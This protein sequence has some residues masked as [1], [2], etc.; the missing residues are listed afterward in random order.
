VL[1]IAEHW[2]GSDLG[3]QRQGN[4]DNYFVRAP[5]FVVAD[6]MGGA[7]AGEVAS[8]IAASSF[9]NGLPSGGTVAEGL[10][11]IIEDANR[12]IHDRSRS[13]AD[14]A[15]MGTTVTAA[16]VG[17]REVTVA[18]V[19]DSRAY[20]VRDGEVVRLTRDHSLVNELIERGKL[21]EEE[22]ETHPQ[23]S[24]IT[25]ALGPEPSVQV[26]L[27]TFQARDGDVFLVCSDGLTSMIPESRLA[28]ILTR[29]DSLEEAGHALI[30]AANDAGGR[31]NITVVLFRLEEVS[32]AGAAVAA[33][34]SDADTSEYDASDRGQLQSHPPAGDETE[35]GYRRQ[36][37][38][39]MSAVRPRAE[40]EEH[41]PREEP[42]TRE[43]RRP[44]PRRRRRLRVPV[45]LV[46]LALFAFIVVAAFWT[47]SRVVFFVGTDAQHGDAVT[48]YQGL[49]YELPFGIRLYSR[50]AGSGV[51]LPEIPPARRRTFTD[52][53]LRSLDDAENLV[54]AL[55]TGNLQP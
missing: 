11:R 38:M 7:Q 52:H 2:Y 30:D 55:E 25:R 46:V 21:T 35:A 44:Q 5:L 9:E 47:A 41:P 45:G 8:E 43:E 1:R 28:P 27:E 39:A 49:P 33:S 37:T 51:T 34:H 48:I 20:L 17:D 3:R 29:A 36:G 15:G 53:K 16:H 13:E 4:E 31:D 40:P 18:H 12:R 14:L 50:H 23:R 19:G 32:G 22:A 6:G 42:P 24:V 54:N 10:A 26:D